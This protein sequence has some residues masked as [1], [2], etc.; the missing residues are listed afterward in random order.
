VGRNAKVKNIPRLL[1][2]T[3]TLL[4]TRPDVRVVMAGEGLDDT[5]VAGTGLAGAPRL[6]CL[7]P[8]RDIPSLLADA[9]VLLLT[10]DNEGMPN[11]V[12]EALALGVP[13]V[14]TDVGD[15]AHM[16]PDTCGAL[17]SR[18]AG[19]LAAAVLRV[20]D[21]APVYREAAA[22]HASTVAARYSPRAMA[23]RTVGVW[24]T[25]ALGAR[26]QH[27]RRPPAA[28]YDVQSD[29]LV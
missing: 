15:L 19:P 29:E 17:V 27:A 22:R 21:E 1:S 14:A 7:G 8:R 5:A 23:D 12:L 3:G 16:L 28:P 20:V 18:D 13:V 25:V 11:I 10:S 26:A 6:H 4:E 24:R 9:T 2:V